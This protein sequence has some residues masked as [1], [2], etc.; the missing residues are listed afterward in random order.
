MLT[1]G[2][3]GILGAVGFP[4]RSV[5]WLLMALTLFGAV[6]ELVQAIPMLNRDSEF[7]DLVADAAAALVALVAMRGL[8]AWRTRQAMD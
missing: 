2:T 3:L 8:L 6:I 7:A 5:T 4:R 1:F